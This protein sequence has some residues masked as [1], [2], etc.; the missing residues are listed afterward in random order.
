MLCKA[1]RGRK[2][3]SIMSNIADDSFNPKDH[4]GVTYDEA[5][6]TIHAITQEGTTVKGMP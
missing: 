5:M 2:I 1:R 6:S 4:N 3:Q